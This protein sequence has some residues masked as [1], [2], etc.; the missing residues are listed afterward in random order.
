MTDLENRAM[1]LFV[2][3]LALS[4][5][6]RAARLRSAG[7]AP[8]V[9]S[10][11]EQL[12]AADREAATAEF[13]EPS[14][15]WIDGIP[16]TL[17]DFGPYQR[18]RYLGHGGMG[19]VYRAFDSELG[20]EVALKTILPRDLG[21]PN[22]IGVFKT[23]PQSMARL[24]DLN[25]IRVYRVDQ[26]DGRPYFTMELID[27]TSLNRRL[28]EYRDDPRAAV[29]LL[30]PVARAIHHAHQ[31]GILHRD[32]KLANILLDRK[33]R[34][35][36]TDFGLAKQIGTDDESI[37]TAA[38]LVG[39]SQVFQGIFGTVQ[40]M[41]PEQATPGKEVTTVSDVYGLG[42]VLY[43]LLMGRPPFQAESLEATLAQVR[44]PNDLPDPPH[45]SNPRVDP[46]LEAICLKCLAKDPA[47]R[48]RS[49]EG[50]AKDLER[51]RDGK[52]SSALKW[53]RPYQLWR[54]CKRHPWRATAIVAALL[55]LA[56]VPTVVAVALL[57]E[58][59]AQ[60][61]GTSKLLAESAAS[62][63]DAHL[64]HLA[65]AVVRESREPQLLRQ[66]AA[67]EGKEL[68]GLVERVSAFYGKAENGF[69]RQGERNR[70]ASWFIL[71]DVGRM[72]A[73]S[74]NAD[75]GN[76]DLS[77]R[78]YFQKASTLK[79]IEAVCVPRIWKARTADKHYRFGIVAPVRDGKVTVGVLAATVTMDSAGEILLPQG[80]L[81]KVVLVGRWDGT[82]PPEPNPDI[83]TD[84]HPRGERLILLHPAFDR[85]DLAVPIHDEQL[86]EEA[87]PRTDDSYQDPVARSDPRFAGRWVAASAPVGDTEFVVVVQQ[88]HDQA[89]QPFAILFLPLLLWEP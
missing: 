63:F 57:K 68:Q 40:Y 22:V 54:W 73:H 56:L 76:L 65:S 89:V 20:I 8:E 21:N 67:K 49:A 24:S 71:D 44:D 84:I 61:L 25:I 82:P 39:V 78:G 3:V 62:T 55:M 36:V 64:R 52:E 18:I 75:H 51:W 77:W 5:E 12:L 33:G 69:I 83:P 66:L 2:E 35:L 16:T 13:L 48:Y 10:R 38:D 79:D 28:D 74:R 45:R 30:V 46:D 42:A 32:L 34:P 88:H 9:R 43:A 37:A 1:D 50:L 7:E 31:R 70:F 41:S 19:V 60:V 17:P 85:G 80:S 14:P 6:Q 15:A 27:G 11:V 4:P 59:E 47:K 81:Q 72:L 53:D 58:R 26:H 29:E 86:F 23:E 87:G